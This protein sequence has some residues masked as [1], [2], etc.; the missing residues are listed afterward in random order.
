MDIQ[1]LVVS[2]LVYFAD[3]YYRHRWILDSNQNDLDN[4]WRLDSRSCVDV[5]LFA[6]LA[7]TNAESLST[8][9]KFCKWRMSFI[10]RSQ[11]YW[12]SE[13]TIQIN[14]QIWRIEKGLHFSVASGNSK[15]NHNRLMGAHNLHEQFCGNALLLESQLSGSESPEP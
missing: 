12:V 9:P 8:N 4:G 15:S 13:A 10:D 5:V 3:E 7:S 6:S 1:T 11:I 2:A 14:A